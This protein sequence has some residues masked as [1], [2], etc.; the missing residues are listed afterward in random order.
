MNERVER[1]QTELKAELAKG[2]DATAGA[3][4]QILER[5]PAA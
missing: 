2:Q 5:L 4:T 3:L 1:S